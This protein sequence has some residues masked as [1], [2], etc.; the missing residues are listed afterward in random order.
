MEISLRINNHM[1]SW[2]NWSTTLHFITTQHARQNS[3][4]K[5]Y[6]DLAVIHFA[7]VLNE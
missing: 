1:W 7:Y 4:E 6:I 5:Y 2:L 3:S